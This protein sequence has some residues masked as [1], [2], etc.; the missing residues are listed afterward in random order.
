M[1]I[2]RGPDSRD[3]GEKMRLGKGLLIVGLCAVPMIASANFTPRDTFEVHSDLVVGNGDP[4]N[5]PEP[6]TLALLLAGL[7]GVAATRRRR[8]RDGR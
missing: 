7:G 5:V 6:G 1:A 4:V 2:G 3:A 8:D